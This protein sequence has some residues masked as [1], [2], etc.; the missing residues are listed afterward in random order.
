MFFYSMT[1]AYG[2]DVEVKHYRFCEGYDSLGVFGCLRFWFE[3]VIN[4]FYF[5]TKEKELFLFMFVLEFI[6]CRFLCMYP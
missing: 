5:R 1:V 3:K 6:I 4:V 2:F